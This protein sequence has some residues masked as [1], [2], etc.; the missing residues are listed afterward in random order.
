MKRGLAGVFIAGV[1]LLTPTAWGY[2]RLSLL[3][4]D[5][6]TVFV[7]RSDATAAGVQFYVNNLIVAG[8]QSSASG[9]SVT[10]MSPGSNPLSAIRAATVTWTGTPG[11]AVKFLPVQSTTK[12]N[13]PKDGQN[14]IA[15]GST[16][17]DLS[18][19]GFKAGVSPGVAAIT[20]LQGALFLVGSS[21]TGDVTDTDILI[22]P[23]AQFSTDGS[24]PTDFQ[25][26]ITHEFGHA[27]G[28]NHSGLI[29]ATMFQT[30]RFNERYLMPDELSF[31]AA[32]YPSKSASVGAIGGK[33]LASDG[34]AVQSAL[35]VLVDTGA[36]NSL[37]AL[38]GA[39]GSY[40]LQ[41]PAGS[42]FVYAEPMTSSSPVQPGNLYLSSAGTTNFQTSILGGFTSPTSIAV[43]AGGAT[44][45]PNLTVTAGSSTLTPPSVGLGKA[46]ASGD[47]VFGSNSIVIPSGQSTDIGLSGG[48]VDGTTTVQVLG[49]GAS[50]HAGT[51]R[52]DSANSSILR[53]TL[54]IPARQTPTIVSI[55]LS[56]GTSTLALSG[57]LVVVPP[58]P[59][60][61]AKSVASATGAP[62]GSVS[63]GGIYSVYDSMNS[64]LGPSSG[65]SPSG[66]DLYGNLGTS[67]GNVTVTFGGTPAPLFYS[68]GAQINFQ[69]PFEVAGQTSTSMVVTNY[70]SQS[71]AVSIPVVA[72]QPAFFTY[73]GSAIAQN[74]PDY[75]LNTVSNA[76]ARGGVVVLYGTGIGVLP[77]SLATG[78]AGVVPSSTANNTAC[79]FG[80]QQS[81]AFAYWYYGFVG[82]ATWTV[83]VPSSA[84]T[85]SIALTCTD[86]TGA[87][88]P[89]STIFVK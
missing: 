12:V 16:A 8:L 59:V 37:S 29:G 69:V 46:G 19:L 88:T 18:M 73:N 36:G 1:L 85:G 5:G 21:P 6:S 44:V 28:L 31:A 51:V 14:T 23:A 20:L 55:I 76:I 56:K 66:F 26:V 79:S 42:Y 60:F 2:I 48:G 58:T 83:T 54:D 22:N 39:D 27:L 13:D 32:L 84:P 35:V 89:A 24:T 9:S 10:V 52:L 17:S 25:A 71:A 43:A 49:L 62:I 68:S 53:A 70:G 7:K 3:Y 33:V 67:L 30:S 38:T 81:K 77:Y 34:S 75:S 57:K 86:P 11:S 50:V 45:V 61:T 72:A 4:G 87:A 80:G 41:G 65:V 40:T 74:F 47:V 82:L 15:V 78:Q 63:P 64:S